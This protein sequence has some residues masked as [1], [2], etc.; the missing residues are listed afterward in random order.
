VLHLPN[1]SE[2]A[3]LDT[4]LEQ[5]RF[6]VVPVRL[7]QT[8]LD[9]SIIDARAPLRALLRQSGIIEF[10]S[11]DQGSKIR[12]DLPFVTDAS[13]SERTVSFYRPSTKQGDPRIWIERLNSLASPGDLLYF[14]FSDNRLSII[15]AKG[16]AEAISK[17]ASRYLLLRFEEQGQ[18]EA[19]ISRLESL[20]L[21]LR[22]RWIPTLRPGPTGVGFTL[23]TILGIQA[24]VKQM[25]DVDGVELK[26][27]RRGAITGE[28]KLV[29]LF[30]KTP[31]W[32]DNEKGGGLLRRYGYSDSETG[33]A[34]LYCSIFT[35]TN[36]LQWRLNLMSDEG[37][38]TVDCRRETTCLYSLPT[39]SKRLREKHPA[40]IFI[41]ATSRGQGALEE[42]CYD[43]VSLC[44]EPSFSNF[45]DLIEDK[46]V[47]LDL[48]LSE[49]V[50][51]TVRDHGYLWRIREAHIVD[52]YAYRKLLGA[53]S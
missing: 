8:M 22:A 18:I 52:L 43:E 6:E 3:I 14:A 50:N 31:Q 42:F 15:L 40:T 16:H 5:Y 38:I 28:G 1:L 45:V 19:T 10:G 44:R 7:T 41:K 37:R 35:A 24:N 53:K 9:K 21:P 23:E 49:R 27:Y 34:Q 33:R 2:Q 46:K 51:G 13:A 30:A 4:L 11:I 36:S 12:L 32:L 48:T 25:A 26:A 17:H 47:C 39:L 29:T 20:L